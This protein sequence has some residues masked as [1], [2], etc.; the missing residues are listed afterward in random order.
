MDP[1]CEEAFPHISSTFRLV[2]CVKPGIML[3][4]KGWLVQVELDI[5]PKLY[6]SYGYGASNQRWPYQN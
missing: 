5:H 1:T 6:S 3:V 2:E 4:G